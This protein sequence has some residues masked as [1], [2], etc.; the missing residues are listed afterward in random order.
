MVRSCFIYIKFVESFSFFVMTREIKTSKVYVQVI[1]ILPTIFLIQEVLY[2][3]MYTQ[4]FI[5]SDSAKFPKAFGYLLDYRLL[6]E[7][8][9]I[10]DNA[11][12]DYRVNSNSKTTR[13]VKH[14][15]FFSNVFMGVT[16]V[17]KN[18]IRLIKNV[19]CSD[20]HH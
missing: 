5:Y 17:T 13:K 12:R 19:L 18:I 4:N 1:E 14:I 7:A 6:E 20:R 15:P 10:A 11:K 3:P 9:R 8:N 16:L 2:L